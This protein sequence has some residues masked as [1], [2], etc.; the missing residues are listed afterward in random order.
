MKI[1]FTKLKVLPLI[2]LVSLLFV[3]AGCKDNVTRPNFVFFLVDDLGWKDLAVYGSEFYETPNLDRLA[4]SGLLFTDAYASCPVCSPTRASIMTGQYPARMNITDWIPGD[5]P[6]DRYLVGTSDRD[7]LPLEEVTLAE[8]L[9]EAGYNT[10]F[11]GKWHLGDKGYYPEDQGF[12]INIGGHHM[13]HPPGGY[14]SPYNNPVLKDGPDGE[15]LTDRLGDESVKFIKESGREPFFLY[16]SF[17]TVH[18]PIQASLKY[19]D[20]FKAILGENMSADPGLVEEGNAVTVTRQVN[21]DYASMVAS[22][23]ENVGKV[24]RAI[25]EKG[26][27]KNT[28]I[29]FTSDNGGLIIITGNRV[30]LTAVSP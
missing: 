18:T 3:T 2:L 26:I 12:D 19:I 9:K 7:R 14:Y 22:M 30:A 8:A 28:Y 29:I 6:A 21:P 25:D 17:Y 4:S 5:D 16:L 24:I 10:F 27:E 20:H 11:A 15:Y 1:S 13:G 23:D